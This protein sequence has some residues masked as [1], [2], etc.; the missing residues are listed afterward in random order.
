LC[1][2]FYLV[3]SSLFERCLP[4][5]FVSLYLFLCISVHNLV[6]L[7]EVRDTNVNSK[8]YIE[9]YICVYVCVCV[10]MYVSLCVLPLWLS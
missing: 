5:Y 3:L 7:S 9:G 10:F 8:F 4:L 6:M 2:S 1:L